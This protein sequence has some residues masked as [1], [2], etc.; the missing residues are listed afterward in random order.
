MVPLCSEISVSYRQQTKIGLTV[1][2]A[3]G[4]WATPVLRNLEWSWNMAVCRSL[5][6]CWKLRWLGIVQVRNPGSALFSQPKIQH[7]LRRSRWVWQKNDFWLGRGSVQSC[8]LQQRWRTVIPSWTPAVMR[9]V[10]LFYELRKNGNE[11]WFYTNSDLPLD[12]LSCNCRRHG[13]NATGLCLPFGNFFP[14][15]PHPIDD[16]GNHHWGLKALHGDGICREE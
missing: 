13:S 2:P 7:F 14:R 15:E 9:S 1:D 4:T 3:T 12:I 10:P 11:M 8:T 16:I 5:T 6:S